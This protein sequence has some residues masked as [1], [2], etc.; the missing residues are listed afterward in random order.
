M[1]LR[2]YFFSSMFPVMNTA[3]EIIDFIGA[4]R[5]KAALDVKDDAVR[6]V[7]STGIMPASW[8]HTIETLAG[9]P[10]PRHLFSFKGAA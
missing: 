3:S 1:H 7:R 5:I 2:Q 8:Y 9:R 4:E 6:K 10:M